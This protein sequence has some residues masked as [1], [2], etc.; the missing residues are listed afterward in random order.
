MGSTFTLIHFD[1]IAFINYNWIIVP[2]AVNAMLKASEQA[3]KAGL[4]SSVIYTTTAGNP[5]VRSGA[6]ALSI[7]DS[8]MPFNEKLYDLQNREALL[9]L[10]ESNSKNK[11]LYL[12][13][14]YRQLGKT[15]EWFKEAAARSKASQDDINRDLLNIWQSSS[16][17]TVIPG[18]LLAKLRAGKMDPSYM[19]FDNAF[20]VRWYLDKEIVD[21]DE[22]IHRP[23]VAGMDTSE[24]IG[25]DYTTF[26]VMDPKDMK[27][28]ATCRCN[29]VNTMGIA[30]RVL[31]LLLK[32]PRM[33]WIPER[34]STAAAIIDF[35]I[36]ELQ[37]KNINPFTR[38]YNEVVQNYNDPKYKSV[39]IYSYHDI[40]GATRG[41]F[42]YRTNGA[43]SGGTS[44]N[45][46]YKVTLMKLLEMAADK[47]YDKDIIVE[48]CNLT[49]RNERIDHS[50]LG[51][52]DAT[53]SCLLSAFLIF[54]GR[55]LHMYGIPKGTILQTFSLDS[56]NQVVAA[57]RQD[58][59]DI[60]KRISV[61]E[62]LIARNPSHILKQGY[63]REMS[64]LKQ[65][66]DDT[67]TIVQPIAVSQ[68]EYDKNEIKGLPGNMTY[69]ALQ[70]FHR[71]WIN[72]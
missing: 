29:D 28:V 50:R 32:F 60:R 43:I 42:G 7:L 53:I 57:E 51:H 44:R 23:L 58:Q 62:E 18:H 38:I 19:D 5:D 34:Q 39:D 71:R 2:T 48:M 3:R 35:V 4:P 36:E 52:D 27:V 69:N 40:H 59:I 72:H 14:S 20:V 33:V 12:E 16:E 6:Y 24:N 17:G 54:F 66:L 45:M 11:M 61:L 56:N 70:N 63:L 47:I 22:F 15:D 55:N 30:R 1:E 13:F 8:A 46:L 9:K 37:E 67:V 65:Q 49:I 26:T 25:R 64:M 21:S 41:V 68:M 31:E 10:I